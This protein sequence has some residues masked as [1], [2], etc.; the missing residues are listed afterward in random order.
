MIATGRIAWLQGQCRTTTPSCFLKLEMVEYFNKKALLTGNIPLGSF[1]SVF[2][3]TSSKQI[4][5]AATKSL[6]M[7]GFF[8]PLCK[9]Q[10]IKSPL[11]LQE[12]VKQAI[13]SSWDPSS[14]ASFI[15][16]FGTHVIISVTIGG[17]DVIY[18][19]QHHSSPLSTMEIK[20]YVQDI[21]DQ[22]FYDTE[23][24]KSSGPM[25]FKDKASASILCCLFIYLV[26]LISLLM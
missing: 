9:V 18:V 24:Y 6:A 19:K 22:R 26:F 13:P 2:S 17:K 16:N 21:R 14:L 4:D 10:L 8:I 3:F 15:E 11:I 12:Y 1:N 5:A 23:S 7:D 20:N 25:N